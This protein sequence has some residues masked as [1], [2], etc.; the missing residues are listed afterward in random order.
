MNSDK[1]EGALLVYNVTLPIGGGGGVLWE[2][3]TPADAN[4]G[5]CKKKLHYSCNIPYPNFFIYRNNPA[6]P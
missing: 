1:N 4:L 3:Y 6:W 5:G 2:L